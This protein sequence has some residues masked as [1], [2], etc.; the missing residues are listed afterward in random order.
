MRVQHLIRK[1]GRKTKHGAFDIDI[2]SLLDIL[3]ILLVFMIRSYNS[4]GVTLHVPKGVSLPFSESQSINTPGV[5]V[6]VSPTAIWVD[7]QEIINNQKGI[8]QLYDHNGLRIIPLYDELVRKKEVIKRTSKLSMPNAEVFSGT[9]NL[10]VDKSI[11]YSYLKKLFYTTAEAGF[12][13]YKLVV[14]GEQQ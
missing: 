5:V 12:Q 14:L 1:R 8:S 7:D 2:T 10:I 3:V 4:S 13:K 6:Q 9:V 11:R